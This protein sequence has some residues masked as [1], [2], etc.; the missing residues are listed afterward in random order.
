[1]RCSAAIQGESTTVL[2]GTQ[3]GAHRIQ[4]N[5]TFDHAG[6]DV[7]LF[8]L[9]AGLFVPLPSPCHALSLAVHKI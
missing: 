7:D 3:Y 8:D 6:G 1:M 4:E 5:K 9:N 2:F